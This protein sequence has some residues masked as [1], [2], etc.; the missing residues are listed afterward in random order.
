MTLFQIRPCSEVLGLGLQCM[1]PRKKHFNPYRISKTQVTV[2][3]LGHPN[4]VPVFTAFTIKVAN[5]QIIANSGGSTWM[6]LEEIHELF[7]SLSQE[8]YLPGILAVSDHHC[9]FYKLYLRLS[10][11]A[12][13]SKVSEARSGL[14]WWRE[15]NTLLPNFQKT[16]NVLFRSM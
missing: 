4:T 15:L 12:G 9:L 3:D 2:S 14:I 5:S 16:S 6:L 11:K 7:Y 1:N 13:P 10:K 8:C